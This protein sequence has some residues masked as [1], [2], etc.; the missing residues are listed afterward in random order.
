MRVRWTERAA[1]DAL[2]IYDFIA[3]Q[4]E[5]YAQSVYARIL[6]RPE[7]LEE[8]PESGSVVSEYSRPDVRELIVNSFRIIYRICGSEVRVL[9]II[10]GSRQLPSGVRELE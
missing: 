7:Q 3:E 6:V 8:F 4:S 9:T 1:K 10:H 5:A 2:R